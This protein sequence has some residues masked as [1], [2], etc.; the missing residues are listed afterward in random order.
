MVH[1]VLEAG[2]DGYEDD[3]ALGIRIEERYKV[4]TATDNLRTRTPA[5]TTAR[6]PGVSIT[7][8]RGGGYSQRESDRGASE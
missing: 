6:T 4:S 2:F 5:G 8:Q 1:L 7:S 3:M